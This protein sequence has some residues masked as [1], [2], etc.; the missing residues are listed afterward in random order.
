MMELPS[1]FQ[2]GDVKSPQLR[3]FNW[4]GQSSRLANIDG[5]NAWPHPNSDCL[6]LDQAKPK[7]PAYS[8]SR[9]VKIL[10]KAKQKSVRE[11]VYQLF[12]MSLCII[13]NNGK[14]G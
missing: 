13:R 7:Q 11:G 12:L 10:S 1:F 9:L 2:G 3:T 4:G 6:H 5:F 8:N 14:P